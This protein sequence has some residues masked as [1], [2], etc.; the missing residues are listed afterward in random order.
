[1]P[2]ERPLRIA[3]L[4][5]VCPGYRVA[6]FK[7][8]CAHEHVD[9][10]LFLGDDLPQ[11]KVKSASTLTGV[12]FERLKTRFFCLFGRTW[13]WHVGLIGR[14]RSYRPDVVLC[15]GESHFLGYLQALLYRFLFNRRVALIHWCFIALPGEERGFA[16]QLRKHVKAY[17][18]RFFDAFLLYSTYGK[19]FLARLG[20]SEDQLFVATNVG[21][22]QKLIQLADATN[23]DV[24]NARNT[25]GVPDRFTVLYV[26]A[27]DAN[28]RP[29]V[30]LELALRCAST[31]FNF[32]LLGQG[33]MRDELNDRISRHH[34]RHVFLREAA[35]NDVP[36]YYRA[37][38]VLLIPGRGGIVISE[39]MA[40][41]L[42]IVVH[43]AD[44]TEFD[45]VV[46]GESGVRLSDGGI[47][48]FYAAI[49]RLQQTPDDARKMGRFG[50]ELL[51]TRFT[52]SAMVNVI[53]D[54]VKYACAQRHR[55][56]STNSQATA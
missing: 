48:A 1:M 42:P 8:I 34:L 32:V 46:D 11:S 31:Q 44:G 2:K 14:L 54:A 10:K 28:K 39:G 52:T 30:M 56:H 45:L 40:F 51:S 9:A 55:F 16:S 15:E 53:I 22:T 38:D 37:A 6:L 43:Q 35:S 49:T 21:D 20:F 3:I 12:N 47:D 7:E 17:F 23:D 4:Q 13:P 36:L 50:R 29:D 27:L 33:A 41:R 18:R 26:G 5:R 24:S 25:I 19:S